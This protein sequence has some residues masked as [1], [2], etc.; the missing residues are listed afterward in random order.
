MHHQELPIIQSA[1]ELLTMLTTKVSKLPRNHRYGLGARI[2]EQAHL[3]L[4]DLIKARYQRDRLA[5]LDSVGVNAEIL[6]MLLRAARELNLLSF[7]NLN[8]VLTTLMDLKKQ[9]V[10]WRNQVIRNGARETK[11]V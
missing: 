7:E 2:E 5:L 10:A 4:Q 1:Y 11:P 9:L 3:I 6:R 8:A